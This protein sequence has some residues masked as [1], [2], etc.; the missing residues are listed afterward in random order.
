METPRAFSDEVDT[1]SSKKMRQK[2]QARANFRFRRIGICSSGIILAIPGPWRDR[3]E[4]I[5]AIVK[6]NAG[7][8]I[9]AGMILMDVTAKRHAEFQV[10]E[11]DDDLAQ[12]MFKGSGKTLDADTVAAIE[13]HAIVPT[14]TIDATAEGLAERLAFFSGVMRKAGG[15]AV[16]VDK[17]GVCHPWERWE[18]RLTANP[19]DLYYALM[20]SVADAGRISSFGMKQFERPDASIPEAG[21]PDVAQTLAAFNIYQWTEQPVFKDGHT[22]SPEADAQRYRLMHIEDHRYGQ[23]HP[24]TNPQGLWQLTPG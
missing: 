5:G 14:L 3:K 16:K 4:L 12:A 23:D 19:W 13:R 2:Q 11:R 9:A 22:F 21:G 10:W 15:V 20:V 17:S 1:G 6:A 24:Y 8:A 18:R 7:Q